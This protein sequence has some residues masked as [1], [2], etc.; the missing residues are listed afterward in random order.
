MNSITIRDANIN[1]A[2]E[3]LSIYDYYV[4]NTAITFEVTT[5]S[6]DEFQARMKDVMQHYPYIVIERDGRIEG[7]AYA[8][9]FVGREAYAWSCETTIYLRPDA[10]K[11]GMGRLLYESLEGR[12]KAMGIINLYACI[13]D[14]EEEDEYLTSNSTDFHKH[15]GYKTV[16]VFKNCGLK[17]GRWYTMIWM[18][19]LI[20]EHV[21]Q[22]KEIEWEMRKIE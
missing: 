22:P 5:P 9:L 19:K 17:F 15:M 21:V 12:L 4:R 7:Y 14:P 2:E 16:G 6:I 13:A 11:C 10:Q 1:D 8:H 20:G 18:E 3:L